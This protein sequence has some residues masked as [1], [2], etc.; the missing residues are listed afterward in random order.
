LT[1][2]AERLSAEVNDPSIITKAKHYRKALARWAKSGFKCRTAEEVARIYA[3][4]C[5]PCEKRDLVA[6]ACRICGC[7]VRT[8]GMALFNKLAMRSE[9]CPKGKWS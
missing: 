8:K 3:K 9:K 1:E 7:S 4:H 6:D 2:A 5:R